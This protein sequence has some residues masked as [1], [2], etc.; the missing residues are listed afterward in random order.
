MTQPNTAEEQAQDILSQ[1][2]RK[3]ARR[4]PNIFREMAISAMVAAMLEVKNLV[5]DRPD[6]PASLLYYRKPVADTA[7]N[8]AIE[9][10]NRPYFKT[11]EVSAALVQG[12]PAIGRK[13]AKSQADAMIRQFRRRGL[14][15]SAGTL[16]YWRASGAVRED[17]QVAAA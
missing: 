10:L 16:G 4:M 3:Y 12:N 9:V 17:A 14:I 7:N 15:V 11:A 1:V 6:Q 5:A 8:F 2:E 13:A